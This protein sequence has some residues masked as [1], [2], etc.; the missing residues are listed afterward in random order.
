MHDALSPTRAILPGVFSPI[1]RN[2]SKLELLSERNADDD[3]DDDDDIARDVEND[4]LP[5]NELFHEDQIGG[6]GNSN[7]I[8]IDVPQEDHIIIA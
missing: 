1:T 3:D 2:N 6:D 8:L 5:P 4:S 7:A